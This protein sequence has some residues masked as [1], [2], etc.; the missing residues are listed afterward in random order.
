MKNDNKKPN[1]EKINTT[2]T[3]QHAGADR[4]EKK[5]HENET[6]AERA[7]REH[8]TDIAESHLGIDE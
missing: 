4:E 8:W 7:R 3:D 1:E 2:K 6:L 5:S